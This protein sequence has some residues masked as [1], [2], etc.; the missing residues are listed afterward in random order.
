MCSKHAAEYFKSLQNDCILCFHAADFFYINSVRYMKKY[1]L[2][3]QHDI[4]MLVLF[5]CNWKKYFVS[6]FERIWFV[7]I[8]KFEEYLVWQSL[9]AFAMCQ[10]LEKI[11]NVWM[12]TLRSKVWKNMLR[13]QVWKNTLRAKFERKHSL[14]KFE[15]MRCVSKFQIK[16]YSRISELPELPL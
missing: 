5:A 3:M 13:A 6:K 9:K 10:S 16:L 2:I 1:C 11:V 7:I 4:S 14:P 12:N 15:R 8:A